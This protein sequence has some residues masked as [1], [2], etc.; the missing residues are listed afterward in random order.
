[1]DD[2]DTVIANARAVVLE[3]VQR[4]HRDFLGTNDELARLFYSLL[5]SDVGLELRVNRN[6]SAL[7][8]EARWYHQGRPVEDFPKPFCGETQADAKLLA[9]AAM[10]NLPG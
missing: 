10:V 6:P 8:Y 4:T 1:M 3:W 7:V 5:P 9:C 2:P